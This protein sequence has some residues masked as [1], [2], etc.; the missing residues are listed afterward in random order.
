MWDPH[1]MSQPIFAARPYRISEM[2][3]CTPFPDMQ[4]TRSDPS[5]FSQGSSRDPMELP[6]GFHVV[7]LSVVAKSLVGD[8]LGIV[9]NSTMGSRA[10]NCTF[11][12]SGSRGRLAV[13]HSC[14]PGKSFQD[15]SRLQ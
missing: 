11:L 3:P 7:C 10:F 6:E 8:Q 9:P 4:N 1:N 14:L 12:V 2:L 5:A 13:E 15:Q